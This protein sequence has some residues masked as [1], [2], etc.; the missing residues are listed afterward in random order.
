MTKRHPDSP[1]RI[2]LANL[3][4]TP[5]ATRDLDVCLPLPSQ[6]TNGA[7]SVA[8]SEA[9]CHLQLQAL[10]DGVLVRLQTIVPTTAE[11]SRCLDAV[12]TEIPI[13]ETQMFFYPGTRE[14]ARQDGDDAWEDI[15][16]IGEV[17]DVDVE[18]LL[19]DALVLSMETLPLCKPDCQGLC[20]VCGQRR[21]TLEPEHHHEVI[22]PRWAALGGL[23]QQLRQQDGQDNRE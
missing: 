7:V 15:S 2:G 10:S 17:D 8:A 20:P 6:W 12:N 22:D 9:A 19:R 1:Y 16:E 23:A 21:E 14:K 13:D 5:G 18:P 3:S 11:C 4:A